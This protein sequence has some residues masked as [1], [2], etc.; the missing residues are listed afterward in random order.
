MYAA[1]PQAK[2]VDPGPDRSGLA[3][4]AAAVDR[5]DPRHPSDLTHPRE[6]RGHAV[7]R[8]P[9][10]SVADLDSLARQVGVHGDRYNQ[11]HLSLVE[12]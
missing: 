1:S 9:P 4:G 12:G 7:S 10:T 11:F 5:P 6:R 8:C 2:E 3:S